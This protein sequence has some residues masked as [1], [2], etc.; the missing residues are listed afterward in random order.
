METKRERLI[1]AMQVEGVSPSELAKRL[2]EAGTNISPQSIHYWVEGQ[3]KDFKN[4]NLFAVA[5]AL[6]FE[7]RWIVTGELPMRQRRPDPLKEIILLYDAATEQGKKVIE[8]TAKT[9]LALTAENVKQ[10]HL[11][12]PKYGSS[13]GPKQ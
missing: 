4:E 7:P 13:G 11:S 6:K 2:R 3:T 10:N 12:E 8:L 5:D 9:L 1:Y